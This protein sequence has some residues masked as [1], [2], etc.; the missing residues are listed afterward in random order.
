MQ[1]KVLDEIREAVKESVGKECDVS[2]KN[3]EKNNG[4]VL[5]SVSIRRLGETVVPQIYI[6]EMLNKLET[7]EADLQDVVKDILDIYKK[8]VDNEKF[9]AI[10]SDLSKEKILGNVVCQL[11]N[12]EKNMKRLMTAP[13]TDMLDLTVMYRVV[14]EQDR[15]G[16]ASFIVNNDLCRKYGISVEELYFAA[17]E[18]TKSQGFVTRTMGSIM[19]ELIGIPEDAPDKEMPYMYVLTTINNI[20]GASVML[21]P[22]EFKPLAKQ[23][24]DDLYVLPS[25]VHEVIAVPTANMDLRELA[26]MVGTIN[27]AEVSEEEFLSN[28]V[29]R[30]DRADGKLKIV[31]RA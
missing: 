27:V 11:V 14:V 21:Y 30:Y 5:R 26:V 2:F 29:Y 4:V 7:G 31:Y 9:S 13:H 17:R 18:N 20:N 15:K 10:V 23:L 24:Y 19:A 16:V 28:S 22:E 8:Q 25:S 3:I 1:E 12:R 6:D